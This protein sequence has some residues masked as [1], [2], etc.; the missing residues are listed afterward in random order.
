MRR[1]CETLG[2]CQ[3]RDCPSCPNVREQ[4]ERAMVRTWL[5]EQERAVAGGQ[6]EGIP[7]VPPAFAP[8]VIEGPPQQAEDDVVGFRLAGWLV[9]ASS[10]GGLILGFAHGKGWL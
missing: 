10:L 9:A 6:M 7:P 2:L 1:A 8:G 3:G 5:Q 4:R